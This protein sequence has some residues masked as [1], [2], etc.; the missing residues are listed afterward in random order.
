MCVCKGVELDALIDEMGVVLR[1][2]EGLLSRPFGFD[3]LPLSGG[4]W[5]KTVSILHTEWI[6]SVGK[7]NLKAKILMTSVIYPL[8]EDTAD[9]DI[10]NA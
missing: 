8:V 7:V 3:T 1:L 10:P 5:N 9:D 2:R 6:L 4:I